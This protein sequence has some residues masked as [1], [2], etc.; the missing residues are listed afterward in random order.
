[1]AGECGLKRGLF[2]AAYVEAYARPA[3]VALRGGGG[4][5]EAAAAAAEAARAAAQAKAAEEAAAAERA[6]RAAAAAAARPPP[7]SKRGMV[8]HE[9]LTTERTYVGQLRLLREAYVAPMIADAHSA[10][11]T[12]GEVM[13]RVSEAGG[14]DNAAVFFGNIENMC[15]LNTQ[16]LGDLEERLAAWDDEASC[17]GDIFLRYAPLLKMYTQYARAFEFGSRIVTEAAAASPAFAAF[18]AAGAA[19]PE[20]RGHSIQSLLITPIQRMPRYELLLKE[21]LKRTPAGHADLPALEA[22]LRTVSEM[23][24]HI[25]EAIRA[26]ENR[27]RIVELQA[28]WGGVTLYRPGRVFLRAGTLNKQCRRSTKP[29]EFLLFNDELVYGSAA[30]ASGNTTTAAVVYHRSISLDKCHVQD[31]PG[32][33]GAA[34]QIA[35][36]AKSFVVLAASPADKRAWLSAV[37]DAMAKLRSANAGPGEL[38]APVWVPDSIA[39]ACAV[40]AAGFG[41]FSRRHHCRACGRV[42]CDGCSQARV[43]IR[44]LGGA[45]VRLCDGCV[46]KNAPAPAPAPERAAAAAPA[47][48]APAPATSAPRFAIARFDFDATSPDELSLREG[49][50]LRVLAEGEGWWTGEVVAA[51]PGAAAALGPRTAPGL[52]PANFVEI[53][54]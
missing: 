38:I 16:L 42:V 6:A 31:E 52:F 9:I 44:S 4:E 25:N 26:R 48:A 21:V 13:T 34:F 24:S 15:T 45:P 46:K 35:S 29:F 39:S 32:N 1:M 47:P 17:V 22:A 5:A 40:C 28:K 37:S 14:A 2:P 19:H 50:R 12:I 23:A 11:P 18:L 54:Q 41:F 8:A 27:E 7:A 51:A 10:R 30:L 43:V 20:A 33:D 36:P 3:S 53:V 49:D